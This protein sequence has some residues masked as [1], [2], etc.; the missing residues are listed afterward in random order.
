MQI[1]RDPLTTA[2]EELDDSGNISVDD[3]S[4]D[5]LSVDYLSARREDSFDN[6]SAYP[7]LKNPRLL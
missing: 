2:G 5:H 6:N 1:L 7:Y 3:L 4:V